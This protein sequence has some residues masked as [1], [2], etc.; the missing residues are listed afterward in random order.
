MD[1]REFVDKLMK[2]D[3][4]TEFC[5]VSDSTLKYVIE[6][7]ESRDLYTPFTNEGDAVAY[8][9]GRSVNG[10]KVAV[11][12]QNSGLTN[13]SSPISSLTTLYDIPVVYVV[14]WRGYGKD[15]P[16]HR[17]LGS[18]TIDL[19]NSITG[20]LANIDVVGLD[21]T[22]LNQYGNF[23]QKF[24]L[25]IP[26]SIT[27]V[28]TSG[29]DK[30]DKTQDCVSHLIRSELIGQILEEVK[31]RRDV[32]ILSTTGYTSRELMKFGEDRPSNFYM[33][34]SMGCLASF[35]LGVIKSCPDKKV[36]ILDGDGSYL[37]RPEGLAMLHSFEDLSYCYIL[38]NNGT[39]LS[40]GGQKL[41]SLIDNGIYDLNKF[42]FTNF[43]TFTSGS[44]M[45]HYFKEWLNGKMTSISMNVI[46][47]SQSDPNLPRPVSSPEEIYKRFKEYCNS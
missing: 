1:A 6:E 5:G 40:T 39:H 36:V 25:V 21:S 8:A 26:G 2:E 18:T 11:L 35:A 24:Y 47:K 41:P 30:A 27:S 33:L 43:R 14:G 16:Q 13:A 23:S 9:A 28:T 37:M 10:S 20:G 17:I 3:G 46:V 29:R 12:M 19:I 31:D 22:M 38:F 44:V 42:D 7:V 15:E 45:S 4:V 32:L 34:G